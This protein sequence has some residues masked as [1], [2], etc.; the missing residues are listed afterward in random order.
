MFY[1][2]LY[3]FTDPLV[4]RLIYFY[5]LIYWYIYW[6]IDTIDSMINISVDWLAYL[7]INCS[8]SK[9]IKLSILIG[10]SID[11]LTDLLSLIHLSIAWVVYHLV[12]ID[13]FID[14]MTIYRWINWFIDFT[15][16]SSISKLIHISIAWLVYLL[17]YWLIYWS[18][19]RFIDLLI[20]LLIYLLMQWLIYS[21]THRAVDSLNS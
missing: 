2:L 8:I 7:F 15:N 3:W 19:S 10:S 21:L 4:D 20:H 17:I 14:S 1:N 18:T 13:R 12:Y 11:I 5:Q 9:L 16:W 6:F